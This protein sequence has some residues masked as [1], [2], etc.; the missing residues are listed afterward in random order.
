MKRCNEG[1]RA[2]APK[3]ITQRAGGGAEGRDGAGDGGGAGAHQRD[4]PAGRRRAARAAARTAR[5]QLRQP[6]AAA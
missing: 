6:A 5:L 1:Y 4:G 2:P 3:I